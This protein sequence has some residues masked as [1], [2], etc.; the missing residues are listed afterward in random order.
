MREVLGGDVNTDAVGRDRSPEEPVEVAVVSHD[1]LFPIYAVGCFTCDHTVRE[2]TPQAAHAVMERHYADKHA[3]K[4][5]AL[6]GDLIRPRRT[7]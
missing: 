4:I 2:T 3:A 6:V 5:A 7:P 1:D